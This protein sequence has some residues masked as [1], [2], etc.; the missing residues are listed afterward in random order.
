MLS[1][2]AA[3]EII[4]QELSSLAPLSPERVPLALALERALAEELVASHDLPAFTSSQMDGYA[5]RAA[6]A[7]AAGARLS[8]AFELFAGGAV[9]G[10]LPA[11]T[12]ARV[13]TGAP[14][15]PEADCVEMQEE[16]ERR[17]KR[18]HFR[19]AGE[20]GRFVRPAGADLRRGAVALARGTALDPAALGLAAAVGR[21]ELS[22]FRRPRVA[23][24]ATGDE[25]VPPGGPLAP[26][27]IH[28]SNGHALCAAVSAAGGVATL[29]APARDEPSALGKALEQA[30]GF[31]V[32]VTSGGA[33]V[34]ERDLV[35]NGLAAAGAELRFW[36]V[37]MRPGKPVAFGRW[38]P[39]VVFALPGNPVSAL[40]TFELFVRPALRRLAGLRGTGRVR[41]RAR[42]AQ[43]QEKPEELEVY[44]RVLVTDQDG[45]FWLEPL[46]SQ[47]SGYHSAMVGADALAVLPIGTARLRRGAEVEAIL[48]RAPDSP[49]FPSA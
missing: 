42:L 23:V 37:A 27:H 22:L 45:R 11:G 47:G 28:E 35:R 32:L 17:G 19:R 49:H 13:F 39:G 31:D 36:K 12:C 6:D 29:F 40:V 16:V 41:L 4:E 26:G 10:P 9:P 48:L 2:A 21:T 34:G 14:L 33:S 3:L 15:P 25:L 8:V 24:L 44:L 7:P 18:A 1:P 30:R 5:L 43:A 20:K 38:G 46:P